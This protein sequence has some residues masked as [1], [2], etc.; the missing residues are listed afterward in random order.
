MHSGRPFFPF[1]IE[2]GILIAKDHEHSE[3]NL[4]LSWHFRKN[5][6]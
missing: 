2:N 3:G 5:F 6:L 4:A 1:V